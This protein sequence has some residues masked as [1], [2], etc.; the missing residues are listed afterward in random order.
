M[1][2][3]TIIGLMGGTLTTLSF[4]PQV[5]RV[6]KTRSTKD[7][8]LGMFLLFALGVLLWLVYGIMLHQWPIILS[9]LVTAILV[10]VILIFKVIYK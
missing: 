7:L 10:A 1:D 6:W 3:I 9:N 8:S 4:F 5:I 2:L